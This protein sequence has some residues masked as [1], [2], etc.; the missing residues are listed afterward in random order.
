MNK[1]KLHI[2]TIY[3]FLLRHPWVCKNI[4][5][6]WEKWCLEYKW[7]RSTHNRKRESLVIV[8]TTLW[9]GTDHWG[10][11]KMFPTMPQGASDT[12]KNQTRAPKL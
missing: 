12:T 5:I 11:K 1:Y 9:F 6:Y 4:S 7:T 2:Y 10:N 3:V 8:I